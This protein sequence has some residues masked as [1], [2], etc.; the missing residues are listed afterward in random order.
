M[1]L[2]IDL[3]TSNSMAA[4]YKDKKVELVKSRTGSHIIPSVVSMDEN[5]AFYTG[6]M[7]L[8]RKKQ[9]PDMTVQMFKRS[10]GTAALFELGEKKFKAEELS[11]ILLKAIKE[12]AEAYFGEEITDAVISVP[13]FFNNPQRKA[14]MEAGK[15]AGFDVKRIINE[16]T[17]AAVAYG[18]HGMEQ[19]EDGI[20]QSNG[21]KANG[22]T[23]HK[24]VI[25]VLDL[26]GGTFDISVMEVDDSVME[27]VAICGDNKL[28]GGDFTQ[29]LVE[30]FKEANAIHS[31]LTIEENARLWEKAQQAKHQ[32]T[33]EGFG[34]I[35]CV[36]EEREYRYAITEAEYEDACYD[37]L[38]RMRKLTLQAVEESK[39][40]PYEVKDIIMVGG[41]TKLSIVRKMIEKMIGKDIRYKINPDEAVVR[42]AALQGALLTREEG[43]KEL[44]MTDICSHY[45]G[46]AVSHRC[47]YDMAKNFDVIIPKNTTIPVKRTVQQ[48]AWPARWI[49]EVLQCEN[50]FGIDVVPLDK[51][52]YVVPDLGTSQTVMVEKTIFYDVNGIMYAEVYI[53]ATEVRYSKVLQSED[54]E[55]LEQE[56]A[57]KLEKLNLIQHNMGEK[58]EDEL[59]MARA[60]RMYEEATGKERETINKHI[61]AYESARNARKISEMRQTREALIKL[62]D[63]YENVIGEWE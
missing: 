23:K 54:E 56:T 46:D 1:I 15:Q 26:G 42:G 36:I 53:P 44:I 34:E 32:I 19:M 22:E 12:E 4:V 57:T 3:G 18:I 38:D 41:G 49:F 45:I 60:E 17:A 63:A 7:A 43:L 5:G 21:T 30:L 31:E 27:V 8:Q 50:E 9:Y 35:K 37:L 33:A 2:G 24:D 14:V 61:T 52:Y 25:I 11:T 59:L 48:Y 39:Y 6:D 40:E 55:Y 29:R 58:D 62:L 47:E 20:N 51:F 10:M 28:G 13:A 16:P